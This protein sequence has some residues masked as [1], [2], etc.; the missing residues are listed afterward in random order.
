[1][2]VYKEI[3][4]LGDYVS[5]YARHAPSR[6]ALVYGAHVTT[7]DELDEQSTR[8]ARGLAAAGVTA[9][10]RVVY[11]GKNSDDFFLALFGTVKHGA[12][13]C[14][15]NWRLSEPE[16]C[17]VLADADAHFASSAATTRTDRRGTARCRRPTL[18]CTER[19]SSRGRWS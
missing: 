5:Y 6:T 15:L 1:M 8:L 12:C 17:R 14:P 7:Y 11:L 16:L 13:F 10:A 2:W 9:A 18:P 19:C 3:R 4:T